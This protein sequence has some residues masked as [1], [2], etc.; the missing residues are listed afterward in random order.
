[1]HFEVLKGKNI[2]YEDWTL[3]KG[4][5]I[6]VKEFESKRVLALYHKGWLGLTG[7]SPWT[8]TEDYTINVT[9]V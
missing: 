9:S 1:M 7:H 3:Q 2:R 5:K 4:W 6:I 8:A